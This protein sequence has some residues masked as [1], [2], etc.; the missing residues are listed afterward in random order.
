MEHT[1]KFKEKAIE[2][3]K[4]DLEKRNK[5][6]DNLT[7]ITNSNQKDAEELIAKIKLLEI[8][9]SEIKSTPKVLER[10]KEVMLIKGF[11]S[12]KEVDGIFKE[13]N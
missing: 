10:I 4:I 11:I 9:L 3:S 8:K 12:E 5:E 2:N 1:I 7:K 6:I 13:F